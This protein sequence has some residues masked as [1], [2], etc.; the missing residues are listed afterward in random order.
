MTNT[1]W[2]GV[3]FYINGKKRDPKEYAKT[4]NDDNIKIVGKLYDGANSPVPGAKIIFNTV[5]S[6]WKL[7]PTYTDD[8]GYFHKEFRIP[9]WNTKEGLW[10]CEEEKE[11]S[12]V[13]TVTPGPEEWKEIKYVQ[14]G[15]DVAKRKRDWPEDKIHTSFQQAYDLMKGKEKDEWIWGGFKLGEVITFGKNK[16]GD[17]TPPNDISDTY[18]VKETE[19]V[20]SK[21]GKGRLINFF[22]DGE[23]T[24]T[25]Y[26]IRT[27]YAC[28]ER[29]DEEDEREKEKDDDD[30]KEDPNEKPDVSQKA[31]KLK[32]DGLIPIAIFNRYADGE[33]PFHSI[34]E[35]TEIFKEFL[36]YEP[37]D[38]NI[39][40]MKDILQTNKDKCCEHVQRKVSEMVIQLTK[41][42]NDTISLKELLEEYGEKEEDEEKKEE[43]KKEKDKKE[44]DKKDNGKDKGKDNGKRKGD[45]NGNG[46][47]DDNGVT[48]GDE[49][50]EPS[51][52]DKFEWKY[53]LIL[54]PIMFLGYYLLKR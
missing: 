52:T 19:V 18:E 30:D 21:G 41:L 23:T 9:N 8:K 37:T 16:V 1:Y 43:D 24:S 35:A 7:N 13:D 25:N 51:L 17:L 48:N 26:E 32:N 34:T 27:T 31:K 4:Y 44:K 38:T 54:I 6:T 47:G 5:L 36:L 14:A 29:S 15:M 3:R 46:N 40:G 28:G 12:V 42:Y 11:T 45:G 50:D 53:L 39:L 20:G 2:V 33:C 49:V 22:V 10:M